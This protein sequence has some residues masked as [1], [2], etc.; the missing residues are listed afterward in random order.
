MSQV[1]PESILHGAELFTGFFSSSSFMH[2][3]G[4]NINLLA[5]RAWKEQYL[6][7]EISQVSF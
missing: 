1:P 4:C 5:E 6:I 3:P 7:R 2:L